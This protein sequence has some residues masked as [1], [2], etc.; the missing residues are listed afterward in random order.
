MFSSCVV[1]RSPWNIGMWCVCVC[2]CTCICVLLKLVFDTYSYCTY[3]S[4]Q[5]LSIA[6]SI[7]AIR[8]SL[9]ILCGL[10]LFI[11]HLQFLCSWCRKCYSDVSWCLSPDLI[12]TLSAFTAYF[13][14]RLLQQV[15]AWYIMRCFRC[16]WMFHVLKIYFTVS[17]L[18]VIKVTF[19]IIAVSVSNVFSLL[20]LWTNFLSTGKD[21]VI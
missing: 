11:M 21:T 15:L 14:V 4:R 8:M 7:P 19:S 6:L 16:I 17:V 3:T 1:L 5:C 10:S 20:W 13:T 2:V 9:F 18:F 12:I